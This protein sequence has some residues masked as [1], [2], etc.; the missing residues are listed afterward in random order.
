[1]NAVQRIFHV[2]GREGHRIKES[3]NS[4]SMNNWT[5]RDG[6]LRIVNIFNA[7]MTGRHDYCV[8]SIVRETAEKCLDELRGQLSDGI[9][10]S[11]RVGRVTEVIDG[12]EVDIEF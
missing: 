12:S 10:E 6:E 7:D 2:Y 4:S 3:F 5:E 8:V 11:C 9:F 1:M